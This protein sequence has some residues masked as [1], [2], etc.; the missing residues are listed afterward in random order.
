MM[1][2]NKICQDIMSDHSWDFVGH[3]ENLVGQCPMTDC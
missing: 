3:E 2:N 1:Y